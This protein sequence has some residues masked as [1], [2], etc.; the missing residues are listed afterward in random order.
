MRHRVDK[1]VGTAEHDVT[2]DYIAKK[3][4]YHYCNYMRLVTTYVN[5][6]GGSSIVILF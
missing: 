6:Q 2:T 5:Y 4:R 3:Q 1:D